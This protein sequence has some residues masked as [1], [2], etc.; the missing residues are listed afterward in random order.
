M[1]R[2]NASAET[3]EG[4]YAQ[5]Q[6]AKYGKALENLQ[7]EGGAVLDAGCGSGL[8]FPEVADHAETVV[9]V[10]VSRMLLLK[11]KSQAKRFGNVHVVQADVDHLPFKGGCFSVVFS[12]TV[13]QNMP[14]PTET[15]RE[16]KRVACGDGVLVVTALKKA[17]GLT[18][19]LDLFEA[20]GLRLESFLD[21][22]G[23]KCYVVVA[24]LGLV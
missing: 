13:L 5:E 8:F 9:G 21:D 23:L 10:D 11:A 15:I 18:A 1:H 7:V 24:A 17:F 16:F 2:Y 12:F 22:D 3:Y 20:A 4:L 14:S 19:F 6:Q